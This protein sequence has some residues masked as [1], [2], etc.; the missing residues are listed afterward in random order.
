M[1]GLHHLVPCL[2]CVTPLLGVLL[3]CSCSLLCR[4]G[5]IDCVWQVLVW[6]ADTPDCAGAVEGGLDLRTGT[7]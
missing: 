4:S 5:T 3:K 2:S 6:S 7:G 1:A